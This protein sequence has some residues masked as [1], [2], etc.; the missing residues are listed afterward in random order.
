MKSVGSKS[1]GGNV[2]TGV[3]TWVRTLSPDT[4]LTLKRFKGRPGDLTP[5]AF[6]SHYL[7]G[8]PKPFDR[9]DWTISRDGREYRYVIDYYEGGVENGM[10]V[11]YTDV[12][13]A[14][15]SWQAV[16]ERMRVG[17]E[18]LCKRWGWEMEQGGGEE[19]TSALAGTS[20]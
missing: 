20:D 8:S 6:L 12:R 1:Y 4:H 3:I 9:H 5:K 19:K 14:L 16:R 7:L 2:D 13:P 18:R 17:V 11:F 10:P 15:D